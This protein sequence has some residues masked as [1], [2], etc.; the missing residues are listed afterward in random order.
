MMSVKI[1]C[2]G[3]VAAATI[4]ALCLSLAFGSLE[5]ELYL[6]GVDS[7]DKT[8]PPSDDG[9]SAELGLSTP[10]VLY[11]NSRETLFVSIS[12]SY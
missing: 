1:G 9:A 4:I 12:Y 10:F 11:G 3:V 8:L 2:S 6:F 5:P 7:D